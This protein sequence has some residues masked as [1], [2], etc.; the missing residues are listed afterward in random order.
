MPPIVDPPVLQ[1][2]VFDLLLVDVTLLEKQ[3]YILSTC[4]ADLQ[5]E[6]PQ[7]IGAGC[8]VDAVVMAIRMDAGLA[9][10]CGTFCPVSPLWS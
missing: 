9:A 7:L 6:Q 8:L 2:L 10:C 1:E 3:R 5:V 4:G